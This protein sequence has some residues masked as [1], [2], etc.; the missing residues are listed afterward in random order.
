[1]HKIIS[2]ISLTEYINI[3]VVKLTN[4]NNKKY[5]IADF[6]VEFLSP[7]RELENETKKENY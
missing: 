7:F 2:F 4:H 3:K 6:D 1:M 5:I